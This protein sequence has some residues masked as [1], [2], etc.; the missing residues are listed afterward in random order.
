MLGAK[1]GKGAE[2]STALGVVPDMLT[3]G[4]ETFIADA[5]LLGDEQIDRGWMTMHPTVISRRSFVGN[6]AYIPDGTVLPENVLIGVH[7]CAPDNAQMKNGDTCWVRHRSICQHEEVKGFPESLTFKPSVM[8]RI[9][10]TLVETFRIIAPH[11]MVIAVGYT[12]VLDL[13]PLAGEDRWAEVLYYWSRQ[14][15]C[16]G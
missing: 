2:I 10:R 3:L 14:V 6:G 13:M 12:V 9:G 16:M 7:T 11:A 4:D 8:R 1:V 5:V 15:C